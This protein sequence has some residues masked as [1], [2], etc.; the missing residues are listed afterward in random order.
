METITVKGSRI[1]GDAPAFIIAEAACNHMCQMD[2]AEKMIELAAE[3][4]V[5][6]IKFQTYKAERLVTKEAMTY[7][8][9]K[10]IS[11]TEYYSKLDKFGVK[12][13]AH[14]FEYAEKK[15]VIAFSTPFDLDSASMLHE[16]G[17][18]LFKVASCDLPDKRLLRHIASF[19][20]PIIL[21]TGGSMPEE[22]DEAIA[23]IYATGNYQLILLV[24]T[25]SYPARNEDA[26]LRR[27]QSFKERYPDVIIGLSDHTEPDQ[28]MVIPAIAVA[29][30]A[31]VI[32][33]HYTLDRSL[34]GSGHAF[35]ATPDDLRKMVENIRITEQVLG[36]SKMTVYQAEEAARRNARRSLTAE[37]YIK[38]GEVIT[39]DLV[40][41]KRPGTGIPANLID[42]VI[43]R[44]AKRDIRKDEPFSL[45]QL[46]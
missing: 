23:T 26:N 24:C 30:G 36:S 40:G 21:S 7:W 12:E 19:N 8:A 44:V 38:K 3:A 11:Q 31:K 39:S 14:L 42:K 17:M 22:I 37:R 2:M 5:N 27:I 33:K 4:G 18:P 35:S 43:G 34:T 45:D 9:G 29:L 25:L 41:I 46:E 16:L 10:Q 32:E 1:G 28:N 20:K 15:G 13:Y 6:A